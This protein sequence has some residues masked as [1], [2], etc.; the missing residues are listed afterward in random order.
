MK[1]A[2]NATSEIVRNYSCLFV[3]RGAYTLQ[4]SQPH[5]DSGRHYYFRPKNKG[6]GDSSAEETR[7]QSALLL[8]M[9]SDGPPRFDESKS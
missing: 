1:T 4:S 5:S 8:P 6:T 7:V 2:I 3:N 9:G